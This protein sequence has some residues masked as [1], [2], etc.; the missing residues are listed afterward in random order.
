MTHP[1]E[2][3][4]ESVKLFWPYE[5]G[6]LDRQVGTVHEHENHIVDNI[7]AKFSVSIVTKHVSVPLKKGVL[8][9]NDNARP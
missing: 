6:V 4:N 9:R 1:L 3:S 8:V 2:M 7:P 5:K